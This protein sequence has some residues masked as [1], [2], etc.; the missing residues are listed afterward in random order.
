MVT[1]FFIVQD[2]VFHTRTVVMR[3]VDDTFDVFTHFTGTHEPA[4]EFLTHWDIL[5]EIDVNNWDILGEI[6]VN[7]TQFRPTGCETRK[8]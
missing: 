8:V 5:G 1:K 4:G 2:K 7:N 6:D 3:D